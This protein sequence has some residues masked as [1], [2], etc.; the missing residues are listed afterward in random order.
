MIIDNR[1]NG[2]M[3]DISGGSAYTKLSEKLKLDKLSA[4]WMPKLPCP[5]ES[6]ATAEFSMET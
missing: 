3:I 5:D 4:Q 6:Q 1:N 2:H